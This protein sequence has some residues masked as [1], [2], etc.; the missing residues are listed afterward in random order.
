MKAGAGAE[1]FLKPLE[2]ENKLV[3]RMPQ[4]QTNR[5]SINEGR[6]ASSLKRSRCI[7]WLPSAIVNIGA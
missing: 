1:F 3:I 6:N 4:Q 5:I 2:N 7:T